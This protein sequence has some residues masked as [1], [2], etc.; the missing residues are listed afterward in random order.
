MAKRGGKTEGGTP[1]PNT[2]PDDVI[3]KLA[4]KQK[5]AMEA[6][7][8]E[9]QDFSEQSSKSFEIAAAAAALFGDTL[10][11]AAEKSDTS[12]QS[13][14]GLTNALKKMGKS[15]DDAAKSAG[16]KK[17]G[18][19]Q[20]GQSNIFAQVDK[21]SKQAKV[22][23][24]AFTVAVQGLGKAFKALT[25]LVGGVFDVIKSVFSFII[26]VAVGVYDFFKGIYEGLFEMA[27]E[28]RKYAT[29]NRR[30]AEE[31]RENFGDIS[32][33]TGKAVLDFGKTL[34]SASIAG[35]GAMQVFESAAEAIRFANEVA[36][37][38]PAAFDKLQDQF[39]GQRGANVVGFAKGLGISTEQLGGLMR[40]A[41]ATGT[42][43]EGLGT[44]ITKYSKGLSSR[45]GADSKII[46]KSTAKAMLD[47]KH[48]ANAT[49]KEIGQAAIYAHKLG[50]ELSDITGIL[51][52]FDTFDQAAENVSKLSQAFGVN[53]D[54]M[55]LVSAKTPAD[56][57]A[58]VKA[59]L[60]ATGKSAD[61]MNRQ[62]LK[63]LASSVGMDEATVRQTLSNK[64]QG[65][66]L[67]NIKEAGNSVEK[68]MMSTGQALKEVSQD[69]KQ[70]VRE[71]SSTS[72][73]FFE[74]FLDGFYEGVA[75]S[76]DMR[77]V[78]G[79]LQQA[80]EAVF[81]AGKRL[82]AIFV[83]TFPGVKKMLDALAS[84]FN[85]SAVGG[86]FNG[87][88]DVFGKFFK[89]LQSGTGDVRDL[90]KDLW[91]E[92]KQYFTKQGPAGSKFL[93]GITE[94][95]NAIKQIAATAILAMGDLIAGAFTAIADSIEHGVD[96]AGAKSAAGKL[97]A[98]AKKEFSPIGDA[99]MNA[100][101]KIKVPFM[102]II[103]Q[104]LTYLG[105]KLRSFFAEYKWEI[106]LY[107]FG[108][109]IISLLGSS[110]SVVLSN[111][112][113]F[114]KFA[115]GI[116]SAISSIGPTMSAVFS[117]PIT[118]AA[119]AAA[120]VIAGA[121]II[122]INQIQSAENKKKT[123]KEF[124]GVTKQYHELKAAGNIDA[125]V[126]LIKDEREKQQK[127]QDEELDGAMA[128]IAR[129]MGYGDREAG[130][131]AQSR[132]I[133]VDRLLVDA[134]GTGQNPY[135]KELAEAKAAEGQFI[136]NLQKMLSDKGLEQFQFS[137]AKD[138][139]NLASELEEKFKNVD[140][141]RM[142]KSEQSQ[143][144]L[145]KLLQRGDAA[146]DQISHQASMLAGTTSKAQVDLK[147]SKEK[148]SADQQVLA[149][150]LEEQKRKK[151]LA[152]A[153][154]MFKKTSAEMGL[155]TVDNVEERIKKIKDIGAKLTGGKDAFETSMKTIRDTLKSM[156]FSL[157]TNPADEEK[158]K[159]SLVGLTQISTFTNTITTTIASLDKA[160]E[161]MAGIGSAKSGVI[162]KFINGFDLFRVG[163]G[164]LLLAF[165]GGKLSNGKEVS[166]FGIAEFA[167]DPISSAYTHVNFV[168]QS[169]KLFSSRLDILTETLKAFSGSSSKFSEA[170]KDLFSANFTTN[171]SVLGEFMG[172]S[173]N[174]GTS[175]VDR[176]GT[177]ADITGLQEK[178]TA[179]A[180]SV[181]KILEVVSDSLSADITE[182][183]NTLLT[184]LSEFN[185]KMGE[186][187]AG[188]IT[189]NI[190]VKVETG[191][192][193]ALRVQNPAASV[194][195]PNGQMKMEFHFKIEMNA[196]ELE[197]I[198]VTPNDSIIVTTLNGLAD[199]GPGAK[200]R[201]I[202]NQ[203]IEVVPPNT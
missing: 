62:E 75:T 23:V 146:E 3:S 42:T 120:A 35:H 77:K 173:N 64:N 87:F 83:E 135:E 151:D 148:G 159:L 193:G 95:W 104:M 158:F 90:F 130:L 69:I 68:Q 98:G 36:S 171:L 76:S 113:L 107:A 24:T 103:D 138:V 144:D 153:D 198:I 154:E 200:V 57:L 123:D 38:A 18:G 115:S 187:L 79:N 37:A 97:L 133:E 28:Q 5:E 88:T 13:L 59:A 86:M 12:S 132:L 118:A 190:P 143:Y 114:S 202:Q 60:D 92:I 182:S 119:A 110:I 78:L 32:K 137:S 106:A 122:G 157:W 25:S 66:S 126:K 49:V 112:A 21:S 155:T 50:V 14:S 61:Q 8:K 194:T 188:G 152:A 22:S 15:Q 179:W 17:K 54:A 7:R 67:E 10:G 39:K 162:G 11:S 199:K 101:T 16:F 180:G 156:D 44:E 184:S 195:S 99:F 163:F 129:G 81:A 170:M 58:K 73:G 48:F 84:F 46:S 201:G 124:Q 125:A 19:G 147:S 91:E 47:V 121:F 72:K 6:L 31:I 166:K 150:D 139:A 85:P 131:D 70:V 9:M 45:F 185:T 56:A 116:S 55:E 43:V 196:R 51:D 105:D 4:Q 128:N 102:R 20:D 167:K 191:S 177:P 127:I 71:L 96:T 117:N 52:A 189:A 111:P 176:L 80:I 174:L 165:T 63:L 134:A 181:A 30:A 168:E 140:P 141:A 175:L 192:N 93:Q 27:Q 172:P 2:V 161:L 74:T 164:D 94:F 203:G 108:G 33:G 29:E 183:I 41:I 53:I 34:A 197:K 160:G 1:L 142:T 89:K 109:S 149:K 186:A 40:T 145:L 136:D 65:T 178:A 82:G 100:F 169:V 26:D